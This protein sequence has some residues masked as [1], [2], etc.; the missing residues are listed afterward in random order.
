MNSDKTIEPIVAISLTETFNALYNKLYNK[1]GCVFED[2]NIKEPD[3]TNDKMEL[4]YQYMGEY[5]ELSKINLKYIDVY[6]PK[7]DLYWDDNYPIYAMVRD[8]D[9]SIMCISKSYI[10]LLHVGI[11]NLKCSKGWNI[12]KLS[13]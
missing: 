9:S 11:E 2:C 7:E 13:D 4:F 12:I 5:Q 6:D 1:K 3:T 10:S 8:K